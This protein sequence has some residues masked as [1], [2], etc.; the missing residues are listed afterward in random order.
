M[1]IEVITTY[2]PQ[3]VNINNNLFFKKKK[4]VAMQQKDLGLKMMN[5]NLK[6][7]EKSQDI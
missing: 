2:Q 4:K 5:K 1:F 6:E 3:S 7:K